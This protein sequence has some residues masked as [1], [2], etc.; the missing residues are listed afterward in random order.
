MKFLLIFC[1]LI[2]HVYVII[3]IRPFTAHKSIFHISSH[4]RGD[5]I[6]VNCVLTLAIPFLFSCNCARPVNLGWRERRHKGGGGGGQGR[7]I[8]SLRIWS[9]WEELSLSWDTYCSTDEEISFLELIGFQSDGWLFIMK[10]NWQIKLIIQINRILNMT[11]NRLLISLIFGSIFSQMF[12]KCP[13][14]PIRK[15]THKLLCKVWMQ[16]FFV[17]LYMTKTFV[18]AF[19]VEWIILF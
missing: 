6:F 10:T 3:F 5:V 18:V 17:R 1:A 15:K 11:L 19:S 7:R 2:P 13:S 8:C 12:K 9:G 14:V 16:F 4:G